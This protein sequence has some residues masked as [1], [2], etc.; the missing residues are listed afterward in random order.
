MKV[1]KLQKECDE[2]L[3]LK[4]KLEEAGGKVTDLNGNERRYDTDGV[5]CLVSNGILHDEMIKI[6]Q[7]GKV[8]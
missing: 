6:I 7:S 5:G 1:Q 4:K 2:T 3:A 8:S